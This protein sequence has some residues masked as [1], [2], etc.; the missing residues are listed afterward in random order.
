[1][2]LEMLLKDL[3]IADKLDVYWQYKITQNILRKKKKKEKGNGKVIKELHK[4]IKIWND[5]MISCF[6]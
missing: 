1:M 2:L 4:Y 3:Q 6:I 5:Y